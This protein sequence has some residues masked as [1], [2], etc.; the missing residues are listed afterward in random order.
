MRTTASQDPLVS[1]DLP[2]LV[3]PRLTGQ[4][5]I[6]RA[7][8]PLQASVLDF[9]RWSSS[10]LLINTARGCLAEY[11][12]A[13]ELGVAGDVR[14]GW[15]GCDLTLTDGTRIEVKASGLLQSWTQK[16][17]STPRFSVR[18]AFAWNRETEAYTPTQV[19]FSDVYV[20]C[21]HHHADKHTVDPTDVS[22]WTLFVVSTARLDACLPDR[23]AV[24]VSDLKRLGA[25][26]TAFGGIREAI[27]RVMAGDLSCIG[28]PHEGAHDQGNAGG[29]GASGGLV[30]G[31]S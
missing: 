9:W 5:P 21:L 10:D 23:K 22:Q 16:R 8:A 4:E 6:H 2:F 20:F 18:K 13:L 15:E 24:D 31:A 25:V 17:L 26:G 3:P 30:G 1:T 12:V 27:E 14:R 19:R 11:L 29:T 28:G 7:G